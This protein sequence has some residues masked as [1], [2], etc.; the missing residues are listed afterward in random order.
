MVLGEMLSDGC[1]VFS[2]LDFNRFPYMVKVGVPQGSIL[3]PLLFSIYNDLPTAITD[4]DV[5]LY[6]DDT[7]LHYFHSDFRQ[8][9]VHSTVCCHTT[10][11][12][13]GC[14]KVETECCEV[15]IY[16][17]FNPSAYFWQKLKPI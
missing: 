5:Y 2:M 15:L 14:Q 9:E 7:E 16:A 1:R 6:A 11:Y 4:A 3:G 17:H 8:L 12:I 10:F 13:F